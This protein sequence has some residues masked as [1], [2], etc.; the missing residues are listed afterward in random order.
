MSLL[1]ESLDRPAIE[2]PLEG[3]W[4]YSHI[5]GEWFPERAIIAGWPF[6]KARWK[7]PYRGVAAQYREDCKHGSMH[8]KVLHDGAGFW[9]VIDHDD[10]HNPDAGKP[11]QHFFV[12][13]EPG[14]ILKPAAIAIVTLALTRTLVPMFPGI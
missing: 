7:Q 3:P 8:C 10:A 6:K 9:W 5:H 13:Y 11:L 2:Y 1:W 14:Q 4:K 12:D